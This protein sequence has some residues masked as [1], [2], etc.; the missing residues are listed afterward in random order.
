M[1]WSSMM[2]SIIACMYTYYQTIFVKSYLSEGYS[3]NFYQICILRIQ[4]CSTNKKLLKTPL[5]SSERDRNDLLMG[6][7]FTGAPYGL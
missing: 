3:F 5:C 4:N 2:M 7:F 6:P 1:D